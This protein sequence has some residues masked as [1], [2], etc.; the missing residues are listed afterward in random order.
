MTLEELR[1]MITFIDYPT[2]EEDYRVLQLIYKYVC[3]FCLQ[4]FNH[5]HALYKHLKYEKLDQCP[6]CGWK[7][8]TKRR[9]ADMKKHL[10]QV[11]RVTL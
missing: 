4:T 11:H 10:L 8:R 7:I 2:A 6:F 9:W 3:P 5:K 1:K